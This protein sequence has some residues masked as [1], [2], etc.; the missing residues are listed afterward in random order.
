MINTPQSRTQRRDYISHED[1]KRLRTFRILPNLIKIPLFFVVMI[2]LTWLAWTTESSLLKW[3]AYL[4][5]GYLWMGIVTFMHDASH[6]TL[7]A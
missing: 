1:L 6:N 4:T 5:L 2:F 7:F 3:S